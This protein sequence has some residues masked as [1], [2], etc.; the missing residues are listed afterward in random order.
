MKTQ[1]KALED[2]LNQVL[3]GKRDAVRL[4]LVGILARG[5][6]LIEDIPG[7]G[8]TTLAHG[9]ARLIAL[10]FQRIQF[11]SDLLP[12]DILGVA[13]FK[14][15]REEFEFRPGPIF[16][17][18]VLAD[19][20]NRANPRTQSALLEAMQE[21]QVSIEGKTYP[22]PEPFFV[23]ATQNPIEHHGTFPLPDSQLD[24]FLL[25]L[26]LDYPAPD[27]ELEILKTRSYAQS[28][29]QLSPVITREALLALQQ[30]V[31]KVE[32]K[33]EL[34]DYLLKIV[35]ATRN[36]PRLRLGASPRASLGLKQAAK[37]YAFLLGRDY[38]VPDDLKAMSIPV[39]RH[40]LVL[41]QDTLDPDK[42]NQQSEI[43]LHE[44]LDSIPVPI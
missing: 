25:S 23:I 16:N 40:R 5:H 11:T 9:L 17:S 41:K 39:L 33:E 27:S 24:R 15:S 6:I 7:I 36:H 4:A 42:R 20:I 30:E 44:I 19:E 38:L 12:S 32:A 3:I 13:I 14:Q 29:D 2:K 22:L 35:S 37:A 43:V 10:N 34:L 18:L 28:L 8:K 1:L 21:R 31:E 26:N